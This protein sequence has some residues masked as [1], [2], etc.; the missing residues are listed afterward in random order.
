MTSNSCF[1]ILFRNV[2]RLK[3]TKEIGKV[4]S[5]W[6]LQDDGVSLKFSLFL[7]NL[8]PIF[9][10][11]TMTL[12]WACMMQVLSMKMFCQLS[13]VLARTHGWFLFVLWKLGTPLC[14]RD[15]SLLLASVFF[16]LIAITESSLLRSITGPTRCLTLLSLDAFPLMARFCS[17]GTTLRRISFTMV[18]VPL[19]CVWR[20]QFLL[21][22]ESPLNLFEFVRICYPDQP[23]TYVGMG[24]LVILL[25]QYLWP[26]LKLTSDIS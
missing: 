21:P 5:S 18:S 4:Y 2:Q 25:G 19:G 15:T 16:W 26:F 22:C 24:I 10:F 11:A 9:Q 8:L 13:A 3:T 23:K 12:L 7:C 17:S 14:V 6:N 1:Q 20:G